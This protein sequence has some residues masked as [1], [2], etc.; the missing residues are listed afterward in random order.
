MKNNLVIIFIGFFL[1]LGVIFALQKLINIS[2]ISNEQV[3]VVLQDQTTEIVDYYLTV[4]F[5]NITLLADINI[6]DVNITVNDTTGISVFDAI[7]M[8]SKNNWYQALIT[9]I[10]GNVLTLNTPIDCCYN[11]SSLVEIAKW[12]MNLDASSE[13]MIFYIT[14]LEEQGFDI[15]RVLFSI[16]DDDPMDSSTFGGLPALSNGVILRQTNGRNKNIFSVYN[17]A[18]FSERAYDVNYVD[19]APAGEYGLIVRRTFAGQEKNGVSVRLSDE[20]DKLEVIIQDDLTDLT[21]FAVV[22]QGHFLD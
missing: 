2:Y 7:N 13:K 5:K 9:A 15:T 6:N 22:A 11:T 8:K 21:K 20:S 1:I 10:N 16:T 3:P 17:N 18:G 19:R 12:N 14:G 4:P